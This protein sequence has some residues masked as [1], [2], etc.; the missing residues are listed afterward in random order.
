MPIKW[1]ET[2]PFAWQDVNG[3]D[4]LAAKVVDDRVLRWSFGLVA[5]FTVYER[6]P[7]SQNGAWLMPALYVSL[8]VLLFTVIFW[9]VTAI[10][11]WLFGQPL[12]LPYP[13]MRAYRAGKIGALL[14]V[15]G[16]VAWTMSVVS[17]FSDLN[18]TTA[19]FDPVLRFDQ[20]FGFIAFIGGF[21]LTLWNLKAVWTG[22]RRWPAKL[23]SVALVFSAFIVLWI[24]FVFH[25]ISWGV[26][27]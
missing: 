23:W 19:A 20:V 26:N 1:V 9:P 13:S 10:V 21:L 8:A 3:H 2:T 25:L 11:R 15:L 5:P 7:A 12:E 16:L 18:K 14:I 27:Y 4:Q 6:P 22:Y 24:A 17:M